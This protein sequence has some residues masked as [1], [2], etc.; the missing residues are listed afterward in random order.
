MEGREGEKKGW[1]MIGK[2][3]KEEERGRNE[4]K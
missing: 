1:K 4:E 2:K 3:N